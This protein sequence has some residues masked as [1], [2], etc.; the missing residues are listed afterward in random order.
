MT[1]WLCYMVA[2]DSASATIPL[3]GYITEKEVKRDFESTRD[4]DKFIIRE[5]KMGKKEYLHFQDKM[6]KYHISFYNFKTRDEN[7]INGIKEVKLAASER[8]AMK[9]YMA[10]D[11]I[12]NYLATFTNPS[13]L[14]LRDKYRRTLGDLFYY[15][16]L[17]WYGSENAFFSEYDKEYMNDPERYLF[18]DR[19]IRIDELGV[20]IRYFGSTLKKKGDDT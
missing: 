17:Y 2:D 6:H 18:N 3:F 12:L 7:S 16:L 1:L 10:D 15:S 20:F 5:E 13:M 9:I 4:M 11:R 8:E 19:D 14:Y